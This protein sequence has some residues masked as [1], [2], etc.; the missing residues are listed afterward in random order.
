MALRRNA[1]L[2]QTETAKNV[3]NTA[4]APAAPK[5][6]DTTKAADPVEEE[7]EEEVAE[8]TA[9]GSEDDTPAAAVPAV[10]GNHPMAAAKE[11]VQD[12]FNSLD[13]KL[14]FGSFPIV[15]LDKDVFFRGEKN[16]GKE[17]H[18]IMMGA[19]SKFLY[20]EKGVRNTK[21][22]FYTYDHV[23]HGTGTKVADTLREWKVKGIEVEQKEYQEVIAMHL[24]P[25]ANG[26]FKPIG[27][28][29]L[30]VPPASAS[31]LGGYRMEV[32]QF[33][34][35]PLSGVVTVCKAGDLVKMQNDSFYPWNFEY[36]S[37]VPPPV[38]G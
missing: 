23:T 30:N 9:T 29:L 35:K 31:R 17:V 34:G 1:V 6:E 22:L 33:M 20:K 32:T 13:N 26:K 24:E 3:E 10:P 4:A 25:L 38:A 16:I 19:R 28:V 2:P 7:E 36:H 37:D 27:H 15:K 21:N 8:E 5:V 14:G 18:C 11:V 12:G